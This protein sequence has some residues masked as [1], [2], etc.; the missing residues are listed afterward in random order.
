MGVVMTFCATTGS[1]AAA[2]PL[3]MAVCTK[4]R[5]LNPWLGVRLSKSA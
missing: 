3:P 5:R 2:N 1:T 4:L